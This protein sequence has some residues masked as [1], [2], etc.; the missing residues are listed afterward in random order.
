M[1]DKKSNSIYLARFIALVCIT[2]AHASMG[3]GYLINSFA[4]AGVAV[5]FL[6]S[7]I[8][9]NP[10]TFVDR[11]RKSKKFV[12]PWVVLG[13]ST[14][15]LNCILTHDFSIIDYFLWIIG[16]NTYLWYLTIYLIIMIVFS[17]CSIEKNK[18]LQI[19]MIILMIVSRTICAYFNISGPAGFL[20]IFNWIG[21]T[22]IGVLIAQK[23]DRIYNSKK[24]FLGIALAILAVCIAGS[25]ILNDDIHY[26]GFTSVFSQLVWC[27][28][29]L[30]IS[31]KLEKISGILKN[32]GKN[33]LPI[34]LVHIS[35]INWVS[36]H[37]NA[38]GI[39]SVFVSTITV[40]LIY[41]AFIV[42]EWVVRK[43]VKLCNAF[44]LLTGFVKENNL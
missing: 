22:A 1:L 37:L 5:F 28:L 25:M 20:N 10:C 38:S 44:E 35:I 32:I 42:I 19:C 23:F 11:I 39:V 31:T 13:S 2:S 29:I 7:G 17:I 34:Y 15:V 30:Y 18:H 14:F 12:I 6:V 24:I 43:N 4:N 8:Y 40:L 16:Y 36:G 33:S 41:V 3:D 9:Y 21:F 26:F 27:Y